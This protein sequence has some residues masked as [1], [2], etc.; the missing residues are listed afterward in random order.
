[1]KS[2]LYLC[3]MCLVSCQGQDHQIPRKHTSTEEIISKNQPSQSTAQPHEHMVFPLSAPRVS[4]FVR[5]I[6]QDKNGH[7]W[8]GTNG[9]GVARYNGESLAYFNLKEGFGGAAVR[10]IIEDKEGNV[11]F[12]T[13]GGITKYDGT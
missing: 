5:R 1:M 10:A 4:D 2:I 8:F 12:G 13:S 6:F 11:W 7:L 3:F 9:D